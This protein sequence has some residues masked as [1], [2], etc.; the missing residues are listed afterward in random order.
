[1]SEK[2]QAAIVELERQAID[3]RPWTFNRK[4]EAI[5]LF[6]STQEARKIVQSFNII[7]CLM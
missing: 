1:M 3:R 5:F 2:W 7:Y 6:S 4:T